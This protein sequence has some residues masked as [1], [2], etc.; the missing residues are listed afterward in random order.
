M[1]GTDRGLDWVF[2]CF[3]QAKG[4]YVPKKLLP[5]LIADMAQRGFGEMTYC[6]D[7]PDGVI[8]LPGM[9]MLDRKY[10]VFQ[11]SGFELKIPICDYWHFLSRVHNKCPSR[12]FSDGTMYRKIHTYHPCVIIPEDEWLPF[13]TEMAM[14]WP[15]VEKAE[16]EE[17]EFRRRMESINEESPVKF[18]R[19]NKETGPSVPPL[20]STEN[21]TPQ[22]NDN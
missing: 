15:A 20:P 8:D 16:Q 1:E 13:V 18:L 5:H 10:E 7:R 19:A 2:A 6:D 9:M 14:R 12:K 4:H 22:R 17:A 11:F 21:S 3:E